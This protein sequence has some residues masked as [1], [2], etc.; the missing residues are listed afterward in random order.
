MLEVGMLTLAQVWIH[1][2][3]MTI[4][5]HELLSF[6]SKVKPFSISEFIKSLYKR[7][8]KLCGRGIFCWIILRFCFSFLVCPLNEVKVKKIV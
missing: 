5:L 1:V 3:N 7:L 6:Q 8:F 4:L 2:E